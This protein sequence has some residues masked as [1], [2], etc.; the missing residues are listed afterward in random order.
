MELIS[1]D[2]PRPWFQTNMLTCGTTWFWQV[3]AKTSCTQTPG[4]VWVFSTKLA[5]DYDHDCD[6]DMQDYAALAETW[7]LQ[8]CDP[9][10]IYC[11]GADIDKM[12]SVN[13]ADLMIFAG[14]WMERIN[15]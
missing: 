13:L 4:P 10:N 15:P 12:G 9:S 6:V 11:Q 2:N 5:G 8:N 14:H 1:A 3:I 7:M